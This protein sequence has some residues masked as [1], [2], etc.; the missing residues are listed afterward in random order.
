MVLGHGLYPHAWAQKG[1]FFLFPCL[2]SDTGKMGVGSYFRPK[3]EIR[4]PSQVLDNIYQQLRIKYKGKRAKG[5]G[6]IFR[7]VEQG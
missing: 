6:A 4:G 7:E 2:H 5:F 1:K 3:N